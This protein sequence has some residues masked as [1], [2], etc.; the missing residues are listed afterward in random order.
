MEDFHNS[1]AEFPA[2][3]VVV[4]GLHLIERE[5]SDFRTNRLKT[6]LISEFCSPSNFSQI[7]QYLSGVG[8]KEN[9]PVVPAHV[10]IH[11]E[12]ASVA[13]FEFLRE[14]GNSILPIVN[15]VGF[16]EQ[17]LGALKSSLF[18]EKEVKLEGK[19]IRKILQNGS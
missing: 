2:E 4:A 13:D 14:L 3:L 9:S 1:L 6:V 11:L 8:A 17:E 19:K 16:N 15:S 5:P 7:S 10:P 18:E 12:L